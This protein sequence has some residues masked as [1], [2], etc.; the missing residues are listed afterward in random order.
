MAAGVESVRALFS[1]ATSVWSGARLR[2][3]AGRTTVDTPLIGWVLVL[4]DNRAG[5]A[6]ASKSTPLDAGPAQVAAYL[7]ERAE[8]SQAVHGGEVNQTT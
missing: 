7:A 3:M 2:S 8:T 4:N 1:G 6:F 5:C